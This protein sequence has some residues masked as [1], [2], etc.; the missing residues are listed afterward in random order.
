MNGRQVAE[1]AR[2]RIP[3]L[4]VLF[5]TGYAGTVLPSGVEV[6]DKPYA[7]DALARRVQALLDTP[8]RPGVRDPGA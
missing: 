5:I 8:S 3:G 7:L 4:P 2:E 6:I 1:V